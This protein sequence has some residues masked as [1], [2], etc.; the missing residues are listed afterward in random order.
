M[1]SSGKSVAYYYSCTAYVLDGV[2]NTSYMGTDCKV[3]EC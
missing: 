2:V 1:I 3:S